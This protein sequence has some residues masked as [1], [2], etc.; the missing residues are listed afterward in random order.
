MSA[1]LEDGLSLRLCPVPH[2]TMPAYLDRIDRDTPGQRDDVSPL[3]ADGTA[4]TALIDDLGQRCDHLG[5]DAIAGIDALGFVLGAALA[6]RACRGLIV[7]RKAGSLPVAALRESF[8]DYTG[9]QKALEL[10]ADLV[11]VGARV[12]IVDEWVETGAQANAAARLVER[13]GGC[14]VG[15]ATI[16]ADASPGARALGAQYPLVALTGDLGR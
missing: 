14:V 5:Y 4:F 13:A 15:I 8:V 6:R 9:T 12:L 16:Q 7:V 2:S 1:E 11:P 3:F 10:R